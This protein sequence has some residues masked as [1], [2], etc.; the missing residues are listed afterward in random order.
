MRAK[1]ED[2]WYHIDHPDGTEQVWQGAYTPVFYVLE[3]VVRPNSRR[4]NWTLVKRTEKDENTMYPK[5]I[6]GPFKDLDAAKVAYLMRL[7]TLT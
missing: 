3:R 4:K 7:A 1:S 6:A 2:G 5:K